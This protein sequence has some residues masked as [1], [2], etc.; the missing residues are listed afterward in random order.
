MT[1]LTKK[2]GMTSTSKYEVKRDIFQEKAKKNTEAKANNADDD[3]I[4]NFINKENL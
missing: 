3:F 1:G 2:L 4:N